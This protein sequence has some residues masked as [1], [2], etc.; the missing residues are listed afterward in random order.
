MTEKLEWKRSNITL[1]GFNLDDPIKSIGVAHVLGADA[2]AWAARIVDRWNNH[3]ELTAW[4]KEAMELLCRYDDIAEMCPGELGSRKVEN[5]EKEL[6]RLR[7]EVAASADLL[8]A[9]EWLLYAA[10]NSIRSLSAR[11]AAR[12]AIAKIRCQ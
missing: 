1:I 9:C 5:L 2:D 7:A 6:T 10:D 8:A 4:K 11:N 12:A 3:A